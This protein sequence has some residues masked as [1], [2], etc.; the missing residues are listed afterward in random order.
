MNTVKL[1]EKGHGCMDAGGRAKQDAVAEDV[2]NKK[3]LIN[4]PFLVVTLVM[5]RVYGEL[6][7]LL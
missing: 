7:N 6:H 5:Q 1:E 3:G 2:R 4:Q